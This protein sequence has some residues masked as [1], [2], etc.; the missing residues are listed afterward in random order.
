MSFTTVDDILSSNQVERLRLIG[1]AAAESPSLP[2]LPPGGKRC[3]G[4][5]GAARLRP[6]CYAI[7]ARLRP[8]SQVFLKQF[9]Q[10]TVYSTVVMV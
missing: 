3:S 4:S 7:I 8:S 2:S 1:A 9:D 6:R 5:A 10:C